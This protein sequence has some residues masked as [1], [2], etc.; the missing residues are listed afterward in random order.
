MLSVGGDLGLAVELGADGV[1]LGGGGSG[2]VADAR[3]RLG[4]EAWIGVSAHD[5]GE[6]AEAAE[7]GAD[8]ATL[9]PI[10]ATASKPGYGPALGVAALRMAAVHR[11]PTF[12]LGGIGPDVLAACRD[13]G[14]AGAAVMGGPMRADDPAAA[15]RR[16]IEAWHEPALG[17]G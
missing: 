13:M 4:V 14:A 1:H 8:Y 16:L 17:L 5:P 11:L 10:F 7:A 2:I 12:A 15:V 9:S 6:V 3:A